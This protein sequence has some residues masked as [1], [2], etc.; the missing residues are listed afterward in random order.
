MYIG[1]GGET[2]EERCTLINDG[3]DLVDKDGED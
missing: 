2:K 1:E 3:W